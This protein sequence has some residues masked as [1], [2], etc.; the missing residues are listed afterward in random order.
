MLRVT[1]KPLYIG[2][3]II[4]AVNLAV[5]IATR[6]TIEFRQ[7]PTILAL[8]LQFGLL[9]WATTRM[10]ARPGAGRLVQTLAALFEMLFFLQIVW[11]NLRLL[12]HLTMM[13]PFPFQDAL[14]V[15]WD[16]ALGFDWLAYFNY[17]HE[18][19]TLI[20]LFDLSYT[21]LTVFSVI[22]VSGLILMGQM[23]RARYFISIFYVTA[24]ICIVFGALM[25]AQA[26]A[27]Y[28]VQYWPSYDNFPFRPGTYHLAHFEALRAETGPVVL[29]PGQLPGLV[30]F[31]SFHTAAGILLCVAYFRTWLFIPVVAYAI[32]MIASTPIFG[33]HYFVDLLAG[34]V[35]ALLVSIPLR[36]LVDAKFS[37]MLDAR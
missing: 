31:P 19:P 34:G 18:R 14:L 23:A 4:F 30:T 28:L 9:F 1:S 8:I 36:R 32:V 20:W 5:L 3:A 10:A 24:V 25:P 11:I 7:L 33:G 37:Q 26:A 29:R 2:T 16:R 27:A 22:A 35:V 15:S 6:A 13:V 17:I 21:S 12:N